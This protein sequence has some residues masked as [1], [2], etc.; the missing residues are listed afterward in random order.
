MMS[1][2]WLLP[3]LL[4][5]ACTTGGKLVTE[6]PPLADMEEPLDLR[7]EPDDE[8]ARE[9]LP[10][11]CFSGIVV[12][13]ARDTLA[14]KLS[15]PSQLR[16]AQVIENSPA[17]AAGL[18]EGD[19][20]LEVGIG[21]KTPQPLVRLSEW[22]QI[23]L[24]S[25]PG[26]RISLL[27]DRAGHD[28]KCELTLVARLRGSA[29]STGERFREEARVG[30][31]FRTATEVEARTANLGPGGGAVITGLSKASPWRKSGLQFGDLI[32]AING[33]PI[34]HPQDLI[35]ALRD[36]RKDTARLDLMRKGAPIALDVRLSRRATEL[37]E[38]SI[39]LVYSYSSGRGLK[40]WS[41]LLGICSY[42]STE[43]AWRFRLL[44][45]ISFGGGDADRLMEAGS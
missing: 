13:D 27:V 12:E 14:A 21:D 24:A 40:E 28:A 26:T 36:D 5:S 20:L 19:L 3:L 41:A 10:A 25:A 37:A 22:R 44:W 38:F 16:I 7:A 6:P 33:T 23:E 9:K 31:T 15:E 32:T 43:A 8:A 45:L 35:F 4:I 17:H 42:Q 2:R 29:R 39:P 30:V 18:Q 34:A 11:G 1:L